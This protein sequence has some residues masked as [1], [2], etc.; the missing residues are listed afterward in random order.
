MVSSSASYCSIK[1]CLQIFKCPTKSVALSIKT[2][3]GRKWS[4]ILVCIEEVHR[5]ATD[6]LRGGGPGPALPHT[7]HHVLVSWGNSIKSPALLTSLS[8][9]SHQTAEC[10]R[11]GFP[12]IWG[13]PRSV[14]AGHI[15]V[16]LPPPGTGNWRLTTSYFLQTTWQN[17]DPVSGPNVDFD[18]ELKSVMEIQLIWKKLVESLVPSYITITLRFI[19]WI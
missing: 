13:F 5:Q 9:L 12:I 17:Y 16:T 8:C 6:R 15:N 18:K 7:S 14:T 10:S 11:W 3:A 1:I 2:S 4:L 19:Y